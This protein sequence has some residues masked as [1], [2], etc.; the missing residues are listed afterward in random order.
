MLEDVRPTFFFFNQVLDRVC[1][2]VVGEQSEA[3]ISEYEV[4]P[5]LWDTSF[6]LCMERS[7]SVAFKISAN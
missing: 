4:R 7:G 3:L 6:S 1:V 5:C 2:V